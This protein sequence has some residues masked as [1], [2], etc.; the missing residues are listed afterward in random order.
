MIAADSSSFSDMFD[1]LYMIVV[2]VNSYQL[3]LNLRKRKGD[4]MNK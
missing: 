4:E 1:I 2:C 3:L